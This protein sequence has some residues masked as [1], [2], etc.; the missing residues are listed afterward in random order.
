VTPEL[1]QEIN[2]MT[3]VLP[4]DIQNRF[5]QRWS[6][7]V[8]QAGGFQSPANR[9]QNAKAVAEGTPPAADQPARP[10]PETPAKRS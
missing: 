9:L 6:A 1:F 8:T 7:R 2:K 10:K 3:L 4:R 5:E